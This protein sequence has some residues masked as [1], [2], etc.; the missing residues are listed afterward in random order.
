M[1][2]RGSEATDATR[3]KNRFEQSSGISAF[4]TNETNSTN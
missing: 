2:L 4:L 1:L 3:A